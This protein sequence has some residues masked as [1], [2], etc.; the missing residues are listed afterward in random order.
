M[1]NDLGAHKNMVHFVE[2]IKKHQCDSV[3]DIK[4]MMDD[5]GARKRKRYE[6]T[7]YAIPDAYTTF[8]QER[9]ASLSSFADSAATVEPTSFSAASVPAIIAVST[10]SEVSA[11]YFPFRLPTPSADAM[12]AMIARSS[13]PTKG[14]EPRKQ[15]VLYDKHCFS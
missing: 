5:V 4:D 3:D 1:N 2:G 11:P 8:V 14:Y 9:S 13:A 7:V 10:S 6:A 12:S 15:K